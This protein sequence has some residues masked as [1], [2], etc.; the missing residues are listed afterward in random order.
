MDPSHF[1]HLTYCEIDAILEGNAARLRN[2]HNQRAWLAW[3][4]AMLP[5][6][7]KQPRL[8]SLLIRDKPKAQGIRD[9]ISTAKA[10]VN[11]LKKKG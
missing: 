6:Y 9:M 4:S 1:W 8:D 5:R 11:A 3:H 10:W 2:E 7:K